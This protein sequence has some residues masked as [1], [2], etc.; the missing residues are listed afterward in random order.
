[1]RMQ[2]SISHSACHITWKLADDLMEVLIVC[3][4][5]GWSCWAVSILRGSFCVLISSADKS[6]STNVNYMLMSE[7]RPETV[8]HSELV[9]C[10]QSQLVQKFVHQQ[11]VCSVNW[12]KWNPAFTASCWST[13]SGQ[14]FATEL[15]IKNCLKGN[16]PKLCKYLRI[17]NSNI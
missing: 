9:R 2:M 17:S 5:G 10:S 14:K 1:M 7:I 15:D 6:E 3:F 12:N 4:F 16:W 11:Y 13:S 8:K